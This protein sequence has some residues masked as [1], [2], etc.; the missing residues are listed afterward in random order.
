M[1]ET[2]ELWTPLGDASLRAILQVTCHRGVQTVTSGATASTIVA[3]TTL[4]SALI[5]VFR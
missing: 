4:V 2:P 1:R 5:A 3:R